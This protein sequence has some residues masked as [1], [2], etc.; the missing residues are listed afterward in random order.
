MSREAP[1]KVR[2]L[3]LK[4]SL[5]IAQSVHKILKN[6]REIILLQLNMLIDAAEKARKNLEES[7]REAYRSL[8]IAR[9]R[10]GEMKLEE[11][12]FATPSHLRLGVTRKLV[13][14]FTTFSLHIKEEAPTTYG[15]EGTSILL[16]KGI[17]NLQRSLEHVL[18]LG[19]LES[20]IFRLIEELKNTQRLINALEYLIIPRYQKNIKFIEEVLEETAREEF[21]RKKMQKK[22]KERE[23]R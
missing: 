21:V 5:S 9:M 14:G 12:A 10:V 11:I 20:A 2:L 8:D 13:M 18:K 1:T 4:K 3:S 7:L 22:G 15:I 17:E 16:D 19:E 6:K 23:V